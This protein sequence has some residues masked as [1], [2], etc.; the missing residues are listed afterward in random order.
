MEMNG[1]QMNI[2]VGNKISCR[3]KEERNILYTIKEQAN[4]IRHILLRKY[5]IKHVIN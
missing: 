3:D 2:S 1:D 4:L 5:F